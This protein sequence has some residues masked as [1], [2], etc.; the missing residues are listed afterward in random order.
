MLDDLR[1]SGEDD[2]FSFGEDED[3]D[4][5]SDAREGEQK[6]FLGMTP[7]ERMFISMFLFMNVAVLGIALLLATG[8]LG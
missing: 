2:E 6:L 3:F 5:G 7:I 1:R 8:R 4:Y